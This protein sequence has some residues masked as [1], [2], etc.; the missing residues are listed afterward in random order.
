MFYDLKMNK[1]PKYF[2]IERGRYEMTPGLRPLG[3]DLGNGPFDKKI[4]PITDDFPLYRQN[5]LDCRDERL[6]KYF[7][8][9]DCSAERLRTL[10]QFI[11]HRLVEESPDLF[12][13]EQNILFC[14]HTGDKLE[15]DQDYHLLSFSSLEIIKTPV[16]HPLD[17]LSLQVQED[18]ALVAYDPQ[19][20]SDHLALLHLCSPSHWAAEDKIGRNFNVIHAPIPGI[21][22]INQ[23]SLKLIESMIHK[24]PFV[25]FIWSFVTDK[26]LN[27]HPV[28]PSHFDSVIW[29]GRTF[30]EFNY[31]PF[32]LRVERQ[33]TYGFPKVDTGFFTIGVS[34]LTGLEIKENPH[35][36]EQL[37]SALNS[38]TPESRVY[39]GVSHCY[40][41]LI[42]W[43]T[44]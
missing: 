35:Y 41:Q 42:D 12:A 2:P 16:V 15:F 34:F 6:S 14:S 40:L 17:A 23:I 31:I 11:V 29:K 39:K 27:H 24:G 37:I 36:R 18:M 5:K 9:K 26:R 44:H 28:A 20:K 30:N 33:V 8:L 21:E 25:R 43:L 1:S 13:F 3:V 32:Y 22:K 4:F 10:V 7:C 19:T 38:M